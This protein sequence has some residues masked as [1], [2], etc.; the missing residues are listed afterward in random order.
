MAVGYE[1]ADTP[2]VPYLVR[3]GAPLI[4][5]WNGRNWSVVAN[6]YHLPDTSL[7]GVSCPN[8]TFCIAVGRG[9][10]ALIERWNGRSWSVAASQ[11]APGDGL[12][13]VSCVTPKDCT[14]VGA[15]RTVGTLVERWNG[16][17]W[18]VV[19]TPAQPYGGQLFGVACTS[20]SGCIAVGSWFV[21]AGGYATGGGLVERWDGVRWS[22]I[23]TPRSGFGSVSCA[24]ASSCIAIGSFGPTQI[25]Q[26]DGTH[27]STVVGSGLARATLSG[28]VCASTTDCFAVGAANPAGGPSKPL[29]VR[30]P[31]AAPAA[32]RTNRPIVGMA[33]TPSGNGYWLVGADGG[34]FSFGDAASMARQADPA[35]QADRRA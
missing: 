29:V 1:N 12:S 10:G 28:V 17:R 5:R 20:A 8:A 19:A 18:S 15:D 34:V 6:P 27:W 3:P 35:E 16:T 7:S 30:G 23:D 22:V 2:A 26:W 9:A 4:E 32:L 25:M 21:A 14:A 11:I 13:A 31:A 33:R 24:S